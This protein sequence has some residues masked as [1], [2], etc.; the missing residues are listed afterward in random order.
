[1]WPVHSEIWQKVDE[2][3]QKSKVHMY[4]SIFKIKQSQND[5]KTKLDSFKSLVYDSYEAI[6][7]VI[8]HNLS[9]NNN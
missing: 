4:V 8:I 6:K 7:T 2:E 5:S 9:E 3:K 1:M